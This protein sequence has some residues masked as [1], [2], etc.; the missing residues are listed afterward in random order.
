MQL[1]PIEH[2]IQCTPRQFSF[3]N[4]QVT[5]ADDGLLAI[6]AVKMRR[7]V[8]VPEHL[9][10]HPKKRTDGRHT[11][12]FLPNFTPAVAR[13]PVAISCEAG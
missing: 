8:I 4:L 2:E 1:G 7:R 12:S 3:D 6:Y 11:I 9:D 10:Q 13:L 5:N